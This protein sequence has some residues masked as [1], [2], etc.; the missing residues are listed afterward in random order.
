[1]PE[2]HASVPTEPAARPQLRV[3]S[4]NVNYARAGDAESLRAIHA[5]DA[6]LVFLQETSAAW[7]AALEP[8]FAHRYAHRAYRHC[9]RAGGL[10]VLSR[11]PFTECDYLPP[12]PGAW[13]PA[14]RLRFDT[15][16]GPLQALHLHLFPAMEPSGVT[17]LRG[18]L[19]SRSVRLQEVQRHA[20]SLEPGLATLVAGD[21]NENLH[22]RALGYLRSQGLRT[23]LS[24]QQLTWRWRTRLGTVRLQL[25]HVLHCERLRA[26]AVDVPEWG[27]SDHLPVLCTFEP[28]STAP[29]PTAAG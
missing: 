12:A 15:P 22:G 9:D 11:H 29:A 27:G 17:S 7:Q 10:A 28:S 16:L 24:A 19:G 14:W 8:A 20:R 4:F 5:A 13:W 3:L 1:M 18:W 21:L 25:D 2:P 23:A 6:D 26:V